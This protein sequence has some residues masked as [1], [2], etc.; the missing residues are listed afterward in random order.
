MG[1][2]WEKSNVCADYVVGMLDAAGI[3]HPDFTMFGKTDPD[4]LADWLDQLEA[5]NKDGKCK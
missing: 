1:K 4:K 2:L 5:K 3:P